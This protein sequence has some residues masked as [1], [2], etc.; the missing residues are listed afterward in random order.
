MKFVVNTFSHSRHF[1][2]GGVILHLGKYSNLC[3]KGIGLNDITLPTILNFW[4]II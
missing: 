3:M 2:F 4:I 1:S